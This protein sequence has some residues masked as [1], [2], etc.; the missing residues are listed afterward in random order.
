MYER[1]LKSLTCLRIYSGCQERSIFA[2]WINNDAFK[3][4]QDGECSDP[5]RECEACS[6]FSLA[7]YAYDTFLIG[8]ARVFALR[9]M[10][11]SN[12]VPLFFVCVPIHSMQLNC[13]GKKN[14][15]RFTARKYCSLYLLR[16]RRQKISLSF[17]DSED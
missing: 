12:L 11:S 15:H 1:L 16:G 4:N 7:A 14:L 8:M 5:M 17:N 3:P 9:Y 6:E 2:L 10:Y 13:D